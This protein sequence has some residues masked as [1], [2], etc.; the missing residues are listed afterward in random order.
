MRAT[1]L[2][3]AAAAVLAVSGRAGA[4]ATHARAV[5]HPAAHKAA[6]HRATAAL[7][8]G[9]HQVYRDPTVRVALDPSATTRQRDGTYRARLRWQ[10]ASNRA[11]GRYES[12]RTMV[13]TRLIDCSSLGSKPVT[14]RTFNAAG[15]PVSGYDTKPTDLRYLPWTTRP[16]GSSSARAFAAVCR[17]LTRR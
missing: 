15:R 1:L 14:A 13:E 2:P 9:W 16:S 10:Y 8:P 6:P 3:A 7:A 17:T 12:Y 5:R 11:I 4:Q